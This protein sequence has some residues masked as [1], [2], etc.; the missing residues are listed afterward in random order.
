[1][2]A[3]VRRKG[4]PKG[5]PNGG[6]GGNGGSVTF[7]AEEGMGTLLTY[8]RNPH[9]R[10]GDGTHGQGDLQN[11]KSGDDLVL[12]VPCGTSVYDDDG[13]LMADLVAAGQEYAAVK[14]GRGGRGNA[15]FVS[16]SNRAP[17]VAEQGEYGVE[18]T[19]TLELK[20][21]ADAALIGFPNAGK[22]TLISV[23]SAAKPKIGD[24][25]FTTLEPNLGVVEVGGREFVLAD[26][27]GLIEGAADGKGLGHE[28]L[29]HV[30]RAR[31]LVVLVDP[32]ITQEV[33]ARRQEEIL[34]EELR[35]YSQELADRPRITVIS[36]GD[37]AEA[38][39]A[40]AGFD[41]APLVI[42]SVNREGLQEFLHQ[43]ADLVDRA[44]RAAPDRPGYILHR[45][46]DVP[47]TVSRTA[48]GWLVE[49]VGA[50]RAVAFADLTNAEAADMA[51]ARLSRLGVDEALAA[52]GAEAGDDV[53][54][55]DLTF[56]YV[57]PGSPEDDDWM[58]G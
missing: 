36:K 14:G 20:L 50:R 40:E 54:I 33:S 13:V 4:L 16:R 31:A 21:I 32:A 23:V 38:A 5:R 46:V 58:D 7:R 29:R 9:H 17:S 2:A 42:S 49:G 1:M 51:S 26:I 12:P 15:S 53:M 8:G 34:V 35:S 47:F 43:V 41:V 6:N 27:P 39:D 45:P 30:E 22:S 10:A 56:E 57:P 24:Y 48:G 25:P 44:E 28:F 3:F 11:G 52:A 18:R 19:L 37:L 55:G